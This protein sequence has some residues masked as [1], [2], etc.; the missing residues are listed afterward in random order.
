MLPDT[1]GLGEPIALWSTVRNCFSR[2]ARRFEVHNNGSSYTPV[3]VSL[4]TVLHMYGLVESTSLTNRH[5]LD[6][7]KAGKCVFIPTAWKLSRQ[8]SA[9]TITMTTAARM[10][11]T[12]RLFIVLLIYRCKCVS[13]LFCHF[14]TSNSNLLLFQ[15]NAKEWPGAQMW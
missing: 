9:Y 14:Q 13:C 7:M 12:R 8:S 11:E 3:E 6:S 10:I 15:P 5:C 1:S 4:C 2:K